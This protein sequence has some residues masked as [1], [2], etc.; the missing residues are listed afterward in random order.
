MIVRTLPQLIGSGKP[1]N[2]PNLYRTYLIG[3]L[4]RQKVVKQRILL[5]PESTRLAVLQNLA[6][7][8]Y[9]QD[10][11]AITFSE[12]MNEVEVAV[13]PP[14]SELEAH[15]RDFLNCSFLIREGDAFRF[16]HRSIMEYL[17][18]R[19]LCEEITSKKPEAFGRVHLGPVVSGFLA[20]MT[21]DA[22]VLWEWVE[23]TRRTEDQRGKYVGGNA[24][25]LLCL[26]NDASLAG[27]DLSGVNLSDARF[28]TADLTRT[29]LTGAKLKNVILSGAYFEERTLRM[30]EISD[31]TFGVI[32][33]VAPTG[34]QPKLDSS[35][36]MDR[37]QEV[38][39]PS[40]LKATVLSCYTYGH[41]NGHVISFLVI[42]CADSDTME[43][44]R[45]LMASKL[46][47]Q[48]TAVYASELNAVQEEMPKDLADHIG[49]L[50]S[51]MARYSLWAE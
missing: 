39:I 51:R 15:T 21:P 12:A 22:S 14:R 13:H 7:K 50:R 49:S 9:E 47:A 23:N 45:R 20:E 5:L 43:A 31:S 46:H 6:A 4:K 1:I 30:A 36:F 44:V 28:F 24:V 10:E 40:S 32:M 16:S 35:G 33:H 25:T 48:S 41:R 17:I 38:V 29:N 19:A 2:R 26:A 27:R 42:R 3:E 34:R 37:I 8:F 11:P 18:A